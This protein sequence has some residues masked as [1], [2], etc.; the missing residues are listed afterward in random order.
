[1]NKYYVINLAS[2]V[3]LITNSSSEIFVSASKKTVTAI[4]DTINNIL[5]LGGSV[6]TC[7]DLFDIKLWVEGEY[8]YDN[9]KDEEI[10]VSGEYTAELERKMGDSDRPPAITLMVKPKDKD[11]KEAKAAADVLSSLTSLFSIEER[12]E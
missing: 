6:A 1:M 7:D 2:F 10:E 12:Y 4:K 5:K 9:E 8:Y 3:D 11:S